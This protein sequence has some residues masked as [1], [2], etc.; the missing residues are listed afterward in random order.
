ML[1]SNQKKI[2]SGFSQGLRFKIPHREL[3]LEISSSTSRSSKYQNKISSNFSTILRELILPDK[4]QTQKQK[5]KPNLILIR[6]ADGHQQQ[7]LMEDQTKP[8]HPSFKFFPV[9]IQNPSNNISFKL[10]LLNTIAHPL[11]ELVQA[12][13]YTTLSLSIYLSLSPLCNAALQRNQAK[14]TVAMMKE[15]EIKNRKKK[16]K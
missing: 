14:A 8:D 5:Q 9:F 13:K 4:T 6:S 10:A 7:Q 12:Y 11:Q 1:N 15:R 16:S 3:Q 2:F